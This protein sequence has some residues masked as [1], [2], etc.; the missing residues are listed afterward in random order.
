MSSL[1]LPVHQI[2]TYT[3]EFV[4]MVNR[5]YPLLHNGVEA[6]PITYPGIAPFPRGSLHSGFCEPFPCDRVPSRYLQKHP[7]DEFHLTIH[8]V[9]KT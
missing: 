9:N 6:T 7:G 1:N 2:G 5:E 8:A 4:H 3:C